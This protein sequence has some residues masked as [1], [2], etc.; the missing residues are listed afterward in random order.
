MQSFW[1]CFISDFTS[2]KTKM[3]PSV[4]W[5]DSCPGY[6]EP[7][8]HSAS[9]LHP[10]CTFLSSYITQ[11]SPKMHCTFT[12]CQ[13]QWNMAALLARTCLE[14]S[15]FPSL[16]F[17]AFRDPPPPSWILHFNVKEDLIVLTIAADLSPFFKKRL[18][19]DNGEGG[20]VNFKST[21]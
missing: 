9:F 1:L 8:L 10:I 2:S 6:R 19:I 14:I 13:P 4:W 15:H 3:A 5:V 16:F 7:K 11:K 18:L 21:F 17:G 20:A 12:D